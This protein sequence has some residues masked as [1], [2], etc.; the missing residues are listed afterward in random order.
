MT[1]SV[2][3]MVLRRLAAAVPGIVGVVVVTFLLNRA[4]PGDPAAFF[5]SP[6]PFDTR[7]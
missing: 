6:F 5:A 2:L 1:A 4:L 7:Q 3:R